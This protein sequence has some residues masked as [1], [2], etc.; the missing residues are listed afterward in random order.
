MQESEDNQS[1]TGEDSTEQGE[2]TPWWT[3]ASRRPDEMPISNVI[4]RIRFIPDPHSKAILVLAP[5]EFMP[6][7]EEMIKKLDVP[8]KQVLVKAII[9][10][11]DHSDLTSLG[12]QLASDPSAFGVLEEN[13]VTALS[14]LTHL[15]THGSLAPGET[16]L[17][18]VGTGTA[19]GAVTNVTAL[20]DFLVKKVDAKILNQQSLWTKDNEEANFFKGENV[21]FLGGLT[22]SQEGG[23]DAQDVDFKRVGM[24]LR[25]RPS[26][27][28]EKN[29]DMIINVMISQLT[30]QEVN[31][32]PIRTEMETTTNMIVE[33]GETVMLGGILFQ[34]DSTIERKL[35]LLGDAPL[36]GGLFRHNEAV[37]R[38]NEMLVFIT[39]Y[40]IDDPNKMRPETIEELERPKEKLKGV[41]EELQGI[42][43]VDDANSNPEPQVIE[44]PGGAERE[45]KSVLSELNYAVDYTP[46]PP[47]P[48]EELESEEVELEGVLEQ[49][50]AAIEAYE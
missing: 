3:V 41:L 6:S 5:R 37:E 40:V 47:N 44:N 12:L 8:G 28:P 29:V 20:I 14:Q 1:S 32:Q 36:V 15:A 9:V 49:L 19:L 48:I 7:I 23:R 24:T 10:E 25:V 31:Q 39:P 18:F 4:G 27:T 16:E 30:G 45:L 35:P 26:I 46:G 33:D 21:P 43:D 50:C 42:S 34:R 22:F 17:G 2:Y 11:V 38:N 13:A